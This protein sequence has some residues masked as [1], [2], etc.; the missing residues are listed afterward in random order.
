MLLTHHAELRSAQRSISKDEMLILFGIGMQTEQRGG[1]SIITIVREES[2]KWISELKIVLTVF[3]RM[4][5]DKG[6]KAIYRRKVKAVKRL[7]NHLQSN[8][9]PYFVIN[10]EKNTVITCGYQST[11][12]KRNS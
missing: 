4:N 2:E 1:T 8:N 5:P 11:R 12:V 3:K 6:Y 7:I 10:Q 9:L